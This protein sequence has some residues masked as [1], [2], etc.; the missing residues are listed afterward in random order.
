M[1]EGG[2][3]DDRTLPLWYSLPP[4]EVKGDEAG[5]PFGDLGDEGL[6][7]SES[8]EPEKPSFEEV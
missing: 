2:A 5:A 3:K 1:P 7:P 6:L 8:L 4:I